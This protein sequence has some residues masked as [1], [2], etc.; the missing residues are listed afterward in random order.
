LPRADSQAIQK[1]KRPSNMHSAMTEV[2]PTKRSACP[3]L[4]L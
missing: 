1:E 3:Q 4:Q 2:L